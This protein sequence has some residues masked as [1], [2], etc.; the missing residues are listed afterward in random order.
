MSDDLSADS[1][2]VAMFAAC[3]LTGYVHPDQ[4]AVGMLASGVTV[5]YVLGVA[6]GASLREM[7][8]F[9]GGGSA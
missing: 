6:A 4:T 2:V 8:P 9:V 7:T 5:Y 3:A 1:I